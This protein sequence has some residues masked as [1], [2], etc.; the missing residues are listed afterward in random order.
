M[1]EKIKKIVERA[2]T[3][4]SGRWISTEDVYQLLKDVTDESITAV[5]N[6]GKQC[7]YTTHDNGIVDCTIAKSV[8]ILEDLYK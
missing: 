2:K 5:K 3:D 1:S 8:K 7:A 4:T 6:T